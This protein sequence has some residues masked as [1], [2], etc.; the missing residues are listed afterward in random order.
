MNTREGWKFPFDNEEGLDEVFKS[1][2]GSKKFKTIP[3]YA[4]GLI[5]VAN[6]QFGLTLL[7]IISISLDC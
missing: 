3:V 7:F 5:V 4:I 2:Y 1:L 6:I